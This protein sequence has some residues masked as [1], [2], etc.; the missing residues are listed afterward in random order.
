MRIPWGVG[1]LKFY[2]L[3][4]YTHGEWGALAPEPPGETF[5]NLFFENLSET[6]TGFDDIL[7]SPAEHIHELVTEDTL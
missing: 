3:L 1:T 6:E 7:G 5:N 4:F 2:L